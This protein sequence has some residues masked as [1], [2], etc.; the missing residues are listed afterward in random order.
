MKSGSAQHAI[1]YDGL[2]IWVE[3]V[4]EDLPDYKMLTHRSPQAPE[5]VPVARMLESRNYER[6]YVIVPSLGD[7]LLMRDQWHRAIYVLS[8]VKFDR[9]AQNHIYGLLWQNAIETLGGKRP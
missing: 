2:R 1:F 5:D 4:Q 3:E 7:D 9:S 8:T 6:H